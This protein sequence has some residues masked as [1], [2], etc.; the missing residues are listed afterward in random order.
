MGYESFK[1]ISDDV[2]EEIKFDSRKKVQWQIGNV[3]AAEG[4]A[5]VSFIKMK[6]A[7]KQKNKQNH[8]T[9]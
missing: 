2:R 1:K 4:T 8:K 5:K 3:A 6:N 7:N 9:N